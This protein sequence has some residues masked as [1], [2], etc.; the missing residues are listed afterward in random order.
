MW[1]PGPHGQPDRPPRKGL[2]SKDCPL[3]LPEDMVV[4]GIPQDSLG[5]PS[6]KQYTP[7]YSIT[8]ILFDLLSFSLFILLLYSFPSIHILNAIKYHNLNEIKYHKQASSP[9]YLGY[10]INENKMPNI[11]L[12]TEL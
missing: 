5:E 2:L 6:I 11:I 4:T 3:P 10:N 1:N 7:G 8:P 9:E 12:A